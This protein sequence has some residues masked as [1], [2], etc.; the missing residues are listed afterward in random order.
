MLAANLRDR[1]MLLLLDN[2]EQLVP[3]VGLVARLL[4]AAPRLLVLATSRTPLR[5]SGEHEYAVPPLA[6]RS[7]APV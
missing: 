1:S 5:L 7:P 6:P 4:A 3:D 2:L